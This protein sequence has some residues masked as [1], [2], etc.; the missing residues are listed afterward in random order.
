MGQRHKEDL[1]KGKKW[2][3]KIS[4]FALIL[5]S[6]KLSESTTS[7]KQAESPDRHLKL[8]LHVLVLATIESS[9]LRSTFTV[10]HNFL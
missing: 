4:A 10:P 2:L 6:E 5:T 1:L 8:A 3:Q 9:I 7:H